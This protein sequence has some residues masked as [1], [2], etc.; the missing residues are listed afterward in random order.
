MKTITVYNRKGGVGKTTT[1]VNLAGCLS[2]KYKK[3][4]LVVDCDDQVNLTTTMTLCESNIDD[5]SLKGDIVDVLSGKDIDVL[6]PVR[7]EKEYK[8]KETGEQDVKLVDTNISLIAGSEETEFLQMSNVY[9][10]KEYL[11]KYAS[12]YDY[13]IID[14]PPSLNDM[15]TLALCA[16]NYVLVPVNSGRDSANGY[17]MVYKAV[18]RMKENGYNVNMKLLGV[19][20][21]KFSGTRGLDKSYREMWLEDET[22]HASDV[23]FEQ[24]VSN[25]SDIPNAYEFGLPIHY[26][27]PRCRSSKEYNELVREILNKIGDEVESEEQ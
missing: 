22:G 8:N 17:N 2:K 19:F 10:L 1:C 24:H 15:T 14:C 26:Y 18:D 25:I 13:V 12:D 5:V 21:N 23:S 27:K 9:A 20:V 4:V 7:L 6:H 3:K 16:T 11:E